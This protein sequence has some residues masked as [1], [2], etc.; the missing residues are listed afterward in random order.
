M[1]VKV[2]TPMAME[3]DADGCYKIPQ[4]RELECWKLGIPTEEHKKE[5]LTKRH[6]ELWDLFHGILKHFDKYPDAEGAVVCSYR[7]P[8]SFFY[9]VGA[10]QAFCEMALTEIKVPK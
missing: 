10:Y 9:R 4:S 5:Y 2:G 6:L 1:T 8:K 3:V 7:I